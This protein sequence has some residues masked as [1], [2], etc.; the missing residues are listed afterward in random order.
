M[1]GKGK[2]S[3][4]GARGRGRPPELTPAIEALIFEG[5]GLGMDREEV[6]D[7]AGKHRT[8]V[9]RWIKAAYEAVEG[10]TATDEDVDFCNA[11]KEAEAKGVIVR[12]RRIQSGDPGWQGCAWIQERRYA[13]RWGAKQQV[14]H[15]GKDGGPI[16]I[17]TPE[18]KAAR[19]QELLT[20][21]LT[22]K[23]TPDAV[24]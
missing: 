6:A 11:V 8:T 23:P 17:L 22:R 12:L 4:P 24:N 14:E 10:D 21:G 16:E 3:K 1:A 19:V 20:T 2:P 13:R 15:T 9:W 18:Q 7:L 5:I